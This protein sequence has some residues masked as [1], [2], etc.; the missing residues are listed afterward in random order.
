M[1]LPLQF[2]LW[3]YGIH[4]MEVG[5]G[6]LF[7]GSAS[8]M[9]APD[10]VPKDAPSWLRKLLTPGAEVWTIRTKDAAPAVPTP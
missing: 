8:N 4:T 6:R 2:G 7:L 9:I 3:N 10:L 1:A 5:S